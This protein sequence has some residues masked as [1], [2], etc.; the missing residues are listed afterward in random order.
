MKKAT[1][2]RLLL[3]VSIL[4]VAVFI[5][6]AC[7]S[8]PQRIPQA[9][10]FSPGGPFQTNI[11]IFD[12]NDNPDLRRQVRCSIVFEVIDEAAIEELTEVNFIIRNAVLQVLGDLRIDD[13]AGNNRD[14][15][16]II[17]RIVDRVNEDLG[18]NIPMIVWAYFTDFAI[19]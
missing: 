4:L 15:D 19:V 17:E 12:N 3:I 11:I 10:Y 6:S 13:V 8:P 2:K 1:I 5:V 7:D 14:L 18:S 16:T 9:Y